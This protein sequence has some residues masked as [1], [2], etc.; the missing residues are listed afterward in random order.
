MVDT[1][2]ELGGELVASEEAQNGDNDFRAQL[3]K[4]A[5]AEPDVLFVPWIYQNV[6]LYQSRQESLDLTV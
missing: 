4:I 3:T 1:F 6:A 5:A 2:T